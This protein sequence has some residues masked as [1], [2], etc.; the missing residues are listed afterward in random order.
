MTDAAVVFVAVFGL[1][2]AVAERDVALAS[3]RALIFFQPVPAA[4][5]VFV[6]VAF[7]ADRAF[8]RHVVPAAHRPLC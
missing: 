3:G 1:V 4:S 7:H 5:L 2:A 6:V 8:A